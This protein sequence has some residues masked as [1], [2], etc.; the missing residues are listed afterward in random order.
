MSSPRATVA[1]GNDRTPTFVGVYR[2]ASLRET[3]SQSSWITSSA[4][5]TSSA[6]SSPSSARRRTDVT[7]SAGCLATAQV[8]VTRRG[9]LPAGGRGASML[10]TATLGRTSITSR[11]P[12]VAS[13]DQSPSRSNVQQR[14]KVEIHYSLLTWPVHAGRSRCFGRLTSGVCVSLTVCVSALTME[15]ASSYQ[16][17]TWCQ[18]NEIKTS[19]S[20][21]VVKNIT[22]HVGGEVRCCCC[23]RG[24]ARR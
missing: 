20:Y 22:A 19:R 24:T 21:T 7:A 5:Q 11:P 16:H 2:N 9:A 18:E 13:T 4:R 3:S 1:S 14:L 15:N 10:P 12:L 23:R 8:S 17:Q 6:S